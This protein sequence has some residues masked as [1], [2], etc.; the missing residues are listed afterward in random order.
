MQGKQFLTSSVIL[1]RGFL[2]FLSLFFINA[3]FGQMFSGAV[4][5]ALVDSATAEAIGEAT[6]S[7]TAATDSTFKAFAL[8]AKDGH[9]E[10]RKLDSGHYTLVIYRQ[11]LKAVVK[12]FFLS[13]EQTS[14]DF[15]VIKMVPEYKTMA[16]VVIV[17]HLPMKVKGDTVVYNADAF[18]TKPDAL[19]EDL[20]KKLSGVQVDRNGTIIAQGQ[21][22]QK[23]YVD[24]KEFF[25]DDPKLATKNLTADMIEQVQVFTDMSEQA[26]F[27]RIDDGSRTKAINLK[28]KKD[29]KT[30]AF[31][32]AYAGYG[33]DNRYN[34]G[35]M[36]NI[37]K[38][39]TQT[40]VL[41]GTNNVNNLEGTPSGSGGGGRGATGFGSGVNGITKNSSIGLNYRD[42]WSKRIDINGS[43]LFNQSNTTNVRKSLRQSFL[44]DSTLVT[45]RESV[46]ENSNG[47]HRANM[48]IVFAIDSSTSL[49]Y[50][51]NVSI[52]N[53]QMANSDMLVDYVKKESGSYKADDSKTINNNVGQV[54][55][56]TN[57][58]IL[59]KRF[60]QPGRTF[61]VNLS[62]NAMK[63]ELSGKTLIN[64]GFYNDSGFLYRQRNT[65]YKISNGNRNNSY[66][67]ILSY[68]EPVGKDKIL[69]LNYN[70]NNNQISSDGTAYAYNE[71]T[72]GYDQLEDTLTNRFEN[73]TRSSSAGTNFKATS[74]RF[75]YQVGL[76]LQQIFQT[77]TDLS[78]NTNFSQRYVNLLPYA[79]ADYRFGRNKS[80]QVNYR[81]RSVQPDIR[82]LQNIVD[83]RNY[84]YIR[85]GNPALRQEFV[86]SVMLTYN[87][88][89]IEKSRNFF[90]LLTFNKAH[91]K[92]VNSIQQNAGEQILMPVNLNGVYNLNGN[93]NIGFPF[94]ALEGG[95]FNTTTQIDL[96]R[97]AGLINNAENSVN[98]FSVSQ[99]F[100]F[101]Y[102]AGGNLDLGI[103]AT[104]SYNKVSYSIQEAQNNSYFTQN[105]VIDG[106]YTFPSGII[107]ST[108]ADYTLFNGRIAGFNQNYLLW[109]ASLSK[110]LLKNKRVELKLSINDILNK[111]VNIVRNVYDNFIEDV[112][113]KVIR[114]FAMLT[115]IYHLNHTGQTNT[116]VLKRP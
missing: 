66:G 11:G 30:G 14:V 110:K 44:T 84:P 56:W 32:R 82:Q 89:N 74:K 60:A 43:Y 79:S 12:P 62:Q 2:F 7:V 29:K 5:G 61:S 65:D 42:T 50:S 17:D 39:A 47:N 41:A 40:S 69:E 98:D 24:G 70:Y 45:D 49:I 35:V 23:V 73:N 107:F 113:N 64:T 28:L 3:S 18:K 115:F 21:Q 72:K 6:V 59:R 16:E 106:T 102:N 86:H 22:V 58:L 4:K 26:K 105:Y 63:N 52:Q 57:N 94:K 53:L 90:M 31:G 36:A 20:L 83:I 25:N 114:R 103:D 37:F 91:N 13:A 27:N 104:V 46:Y 92:I 33:T 51:P 9:F 95:E 93:I 99:G 10:V 54:R 101:N 88:F 80:L 96:S 8:S 1:K 109:N 111:R 116:P 19:V 67:V 68:T 108:N 75:N 112:R 71:L 15:G 81:G 55:N 34:A 78:K 87:S 77:S 48:K 38:G 76:A 100:D 97:N 85:K